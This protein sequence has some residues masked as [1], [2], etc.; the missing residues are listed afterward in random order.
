M[1]C[2]ATG[3]YI[4]FPSDPHSLENAAKML[5]KAMRGFGTKDSQLIRVLAHRTPQQIQ[6]ITEIFDREFGGG[7]TLVE[8][9]QNETSGDF[10]RL[11]VNLLT[12]AAERD[13]QMIYKAMKGIGT[14]DNELREIL[15]T[16]SAA[17]I[18]KMSEAY[19]AKYDKKLADAIAGETTFNYKLLTVALTD[20]A[21]FIAE[22]LQD[23]VKNAGT[24]DDRLARILS[25]IPRSNARGLSFTTNYADHF[26]EGWAAE[27]ED[28][29]SMPDLQAV[30][31]A[32]LQLTG[33]DLVKVV[34]KETSGNYQRLCLNL[35]ASPDEMAAEK[36]HEA[37]SG[38]GT[39]DDLLIE[40]FCTYSNSRL[41]AIKIAYEKQYGKSLE[42][43]LRK[44]TSG[45]YL[46]LM[47]DLCRPRAAKVA[48]SCRQAME[49][50]GTQDER[51]VTNLVGRSRHMLRAVSVA[52]EQEYGKPLK[53]AIR[54]ETSFWYKRALSYF[55]DQAEEQTHFVHPSHLLR[56]RDL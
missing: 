29:F 19:E 21:V 5:H 32:Y 55:I 1:P 35:L 4:Y 8:W 34:K 17:S 31:A 40:L 56:V 36:F 26:H 7:K 46:K 52:Y 28:D 47:L 43:G 18:R 38:A 12:P 9:I 15:V 51:L 48:E 44:E 53:K 54:S 49:D 42:D 14:D 2:A 23:A 50:V 11:L 30:K 39:N 6:G 13:A 45:D 27:L 16:R 22:R 24:D 20:R 25:S 3:L 33:K 10:K 37:F 41:Q